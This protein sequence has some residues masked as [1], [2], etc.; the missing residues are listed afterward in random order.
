ME[1][2][3]KKLNIEKPKTLKTSQNDK[4]FLKKRKQLNLPGLGM[5]WLDLDHKQNSV[6]KKEQNREKKIE[7]IHLNAFL[8][9]M[10]FY[11]VSAQNISHIQKGGSWAFW[12][13]IC[14]VSCW[15]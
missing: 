10:S 13:V 14:I 1:K 7:I 8:C 9:F 6:E 11:C 15:L 5:V 3:K 2:E 12:M 4:S